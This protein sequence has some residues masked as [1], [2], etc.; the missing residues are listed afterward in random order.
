MRSE[1]DGGFGEVV[2]G[3]CRDAEVEVTMLVMMV[4]GE[5]GGGGA[6][7]VEADKDE[8]GDVDKGGDKGGMMVRQSWRWRSGGCDGGRSEEGG[9]QR[10]GGGE[11]VAVWRSRV[12]WFQEE[13]CAGVI[14][15][16][17]WEM[18]IWEHECFQ[19][20][21]IWVTCFQE[22]LLL[23]LCN[24]KCPLQHWLLLLLM[25]HLKNKGRSR[26]GVHAARSFMD[27]SY[28]IFCLEWSDTSQPWVP[29]V[30]YWIMLYSLAMYDPLIW[31]ATRRELTFA[32]RLVRISPSLDLFKH[33]DPSV[34]KVYGFGMSSSTSMSVT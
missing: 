29:S 1:G 27:L 23:L 9:G 31:F 32:D 17:T 10:D 15:V 2:D 26:S 13:G 21:T 8:G 25:S 5:D 18:E 3:C 7:V 22:M 19:S 24:N 16:G 4:S 12:R 6:T 34:N 20:Y 14:L 28:R 33:E 30:S 11:R